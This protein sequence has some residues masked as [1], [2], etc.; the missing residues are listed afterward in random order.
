[1]GNKHI[2]RDKIDQEMM[3]VA[4]P[5]RRKKERMNEYGK[6]QYKNI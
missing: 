3:H 2:V 5:T 1:M 4:T 6:N